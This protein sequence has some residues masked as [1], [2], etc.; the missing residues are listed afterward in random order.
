MNH[1][2]IQTKGKNNDLFKVLSSKNNIFLLPDDLENPKVYDSDYKL[3][4]D[5]WFHIPNFSN[6]EYCLDML[7]RPFISSEYN[8][9]GKVDIN[10]F[11]FLCSYQSGVYFFQKVTPSLIINK[12]W[13]RLSNEPAMEE[14]SPIIVINEIPDAI[15]I[16]SKDT[17]YFKK[18]SSITSIFKGIIELYKEATQL[19]TEEFLSYK[20][21][22]LEND[23]TASKVKTANRKRIALAMNTIKD[24]TEEQRSSIF[25]YIKS[26][27]ADL[28]F[29]KENS[30]FKINNEEDLK[31][32]L[33][34]IEQ[35]YYTT[36]IGN[37]KRVANSV[38]K[39]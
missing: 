19:E 20:F 6:K 32:L 39:I 8:Q 3:E 17:L 22:K 25:S 9:M 2:I 33:W 18:I 30:K 31:Q 27:C 12:K 36:P 10:K 38:S 16:K 26:Y 35:R 13:F 23:Y 29:D 28:S 24:F 4:D 21:I 7:K 14:Q 15:Y 34:G 37:E 5:E 11:L 1:L